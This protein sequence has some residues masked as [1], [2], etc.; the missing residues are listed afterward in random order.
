MAVPQEWVK[1]LA[2]NKRVPD[3]VVPHG[4][5]GHECYLAS[6]VLPMGY[7]NSVSIAQHVHRNLVMQ[8]QSG[9]DGPGVNLPEQE[10]RKDQP[11][12]VADPHWRAYLDNDLLERV[13][14]IRCPEIV[15]TT[16][17]EVKSLL[18]EYQRWEVPRNAKKSVS[19]AKQ[20]E[21]QG[22]QVDGWEGKAFPKEGKLCKYL[23]AS[24]HLCQ[25]ERVSQ[26]RLQV[27]CGGLVYMAMFRRPLLGS[28]NHVWTFIE[29]FREG[30]P[31]F[32]VLPP[33]CRLEILRFL[34]LSPLA[35]FD[36]RMA[37]DPIVSCSDASTS[38]GGICISK[39]LSQ[40]GSL[41]CQGKL[42]GE[43]SEIRGDDQVLCV[44]LFDGIGALRVALDLLG[45]KVLGHVS[46]EI[47]SQANR[48]IE[49]HFPEVELYPKVED[50]SEADVK[51]WSL[52]Y[53]Q[54]AM[55]ILGA[56]PPCQGVSGL[57]AD[58]RGA[59]K[60]ER[61][62]LFV[63]VKRISGLLKIYFPWCQVHVLMESVASMDDKDREVM[64]QSFEDTPWEIDS[65]SMTW[66]SRP[67]LYWI[68]WDLAEQ[69]GVYITMSGDKRSV[70]LIGNQSLDE[71]CLPGWTKADPSRPFPTFTTSRPRTY[72]G[73]KPA[74]LLGCTPEEVRRWQ[75][76]SHR[77]PP[78][79]YANRNCVFNKHGVYRVANIQEREY[80]M[81]FPVG[82]TK[83]CVP[84]SQR[85]GKEAE[86]IRLSL[87][88]N[89]WSVP[90]VAWLLGQLLAKQG[91]A[92]YHAPQDVLEK[93]KADHLSSLQA[94]L[95]RSPLGNIN[96][97]HTPG[98]AG[99]LVTKLANLVSMK[100][101]DVMLTT[102]TSQ[103]QKYHR[104]RASVPSR[105]WKWRI[106]SG[107]KWTGQREH[108]NSL[109]LRACF[110]TLKWRV[111][112]QKLRGKRFLHLTDSLVSLHCLTRGRSSSRKLRRT[113][114]RVNALLL[115]SSCQALWG[116]VHTEQN[117]ADKPSRWG[118][119][120]RTKFRYAKK[121]A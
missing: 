42:R 97:Q 6:R 83:N 59:L 84:K 57:N 93:L 22:A 72:P 68:S 55:V 109:E 99:V 30:S 15:G 71:V 28:L 101:E 89:S 4:C 69:E 44:G 26:R 39:G 38:G 35:R 75:E 24:L 111:I 108:I 50:I 20:A 32:R 62:C 16:A 18:E 81:G 66:C 116:Y 119:R 2:F 95:F 27:V 73:R 47:N 53:S 77:F 113:M 60:D 17:P 56:G 9:R 3:S 118:A 8:L 61:S 23:T 103:M 78:Y 14:A 85:K 40:V 106:L 43:V 70:T 115:I 94:R 87:I 13:E 11:F 19:R 117:P 120:V 64:S 63:H 102:P 34:S 100:G 105:L 74:G 49:S 31:R 48:V 5:Q 76:D 52:K 96:H 88:G 107:W 121:G 33:V 92:D 112:H 36:F 10:L 82:F 1:Y 110:T 91:F 67:R 51:A 104:L 7:L 25:Q 65:G 58:R 37:V 21:V 54:A 114:C 90:V 86:D 80:M 45:C 41:A 79:Q 98:E 29:S 46:V 12:S